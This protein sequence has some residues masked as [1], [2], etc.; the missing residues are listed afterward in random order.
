MGSIKPP[1]L[2]KYFTGVLLSKRYL[3]DEVRSILEKKL[4]EIELES[5]FYDFDFTDYYAE[6]MGREISRKF[7]IFKGLYPPDYLPELKIKTNEI[8]GQFAGIDGFR[9]PVNLDP[10]YLESSK[11]ILASTK[12]F[13]HRI[14]IGKGIFAEVTMHW[15]GKEWNFFEWTYPDYRSREYRNFFSMARKRYIREINGS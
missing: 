3:W 2:V 7:V 10:G 6:E 9:R 14:Y 1:P 12:N 4:F 5:E 13:F 8:E 15:R 11:L